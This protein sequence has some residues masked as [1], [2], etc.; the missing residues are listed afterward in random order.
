MALA[1]HE[2]HDLDVE[3]VRF[4]DS[5][6]PVERFA[7]GLELEYIHFAIEAAQGDGQVHLCRIKLLASHRRE[8]AEHRRH[9]VLEY[10]HLQR[11]VAIAEHP[12]IVWSLL[13]RGGLA[14]FTGRLV[15]STTGGKRHHRQQGGQ[16]RDK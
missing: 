13:G 11:K 8:D 5:S 2:G 3:A 16:N 12:A 7:V 6:L 15:G 1:I 9:T 14:M 10:G 4:D